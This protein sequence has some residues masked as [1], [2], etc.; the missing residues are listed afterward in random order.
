MSS[1]MNVGQAVVESLRQEGVRHIFGSVGSAFL[2]ILDAM[3]D[4]TD[5]E[6]IGVRHEQAG[7][8]MADGYARVTGQPSVCM[9]TN[10]PGVINLT[11]GVAAAHVAHSPMVILAPSASR[12]P[13]QPN[14]RP[15]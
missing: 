7:A 2:D 15:R 3:Y 8:L 13:Q 10:G 12:E 6:F 14:R 4:R 1:S 5:I 9:A 11:Y